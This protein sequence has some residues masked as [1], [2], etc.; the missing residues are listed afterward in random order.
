MKITK[1]EKI[2]TK[3]KV[4][5]DLPK[6]IVLLPSVVEDFK[7]YVGKEI[8]DKTFYEIV[9]ANEVTDLFEFAL[10]KTLIKDYSVHKLKTILYKKNKNKTVVEEVIKKLKKYRIINEDEIIANVLEHIDR[11][12]YG[13][14]KAIN[15][16]KSKEISLDKIDKLKCDPTKEKQKALE[17]TKRLVKRYKSKNTVNLKRNIYSGLIR[18]G[19]DDSIA[20]GMLSKVSN[21]P[22]NE[23]NMLELQ[24]KKLFSSYSRKLK[25]KELTNKII[26]SLQSKGY[27][28]DD[29]KRII[30]EENTYE[31][32]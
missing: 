6:T 21:S 27:R 28:I 18:L 2:K 1:I 31:M 3:Y 26:K 13:F 4:V 14:N 25:G 20:E 15:M 30:K 7:L 24:Y 9:K 29:I 5:F 8:E 23:L 17:Q 12:K 32:D 10:K 11:K 22:E 16:L 19:F